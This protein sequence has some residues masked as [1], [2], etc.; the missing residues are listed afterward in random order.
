VGKSQRV[1]VY[2]F[3]GSPKIQPVVPFTEARGSIEG[4]LDGLRNYK[5]RD[6]STN[7]NGAVVEGLRTLKRELDR[8]HRPLKFGTLVVFTDGTDRAARV[9]RAELEDEMGKPEYATYELLAIGVGAELDSGQLSAVGRDGTELAENLGKVEAAFD[10]M[11]LR[12]EGHRK[13]FYLLSYCTPSRNGDHRVEIRARTND[14]T[15]SLEYGFSANGFGPPPDCDPQRRPT[16]SLQAEAEQ[17]AASD[18][19]PPTK[20]EQQTEP[21]AE[22]AEPPPKTE[23]PPQKP[24]EYAP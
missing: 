7:L 21:K 20:S 3:D 19:G 24:V 6:P 17:Q 16:F 12:I 9:T 4:G 1:A 5:P 11:A 15:G 14:G 10:K 8:D 2:A 23:P 18:S 22:K 13:R